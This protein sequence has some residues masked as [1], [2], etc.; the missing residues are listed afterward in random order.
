MTAEAG[1]FQWHPKEK[2]GGLLRRRCTCPRRLLAAKA[3]RDCREGAVESEI[4]CPPRVD[5]GVHRAKEEIGAIAEADF[6]IGLAHG[7]AGKAAEIGDGDGAG[8][9][10]AMQMSVKWD[11]LP[12]SSRYIAIE[13]V[14]TS[15]VFDL[16]LLSAEQDGSI[17]SPIDSD[18]ACLGIA[19]QCSRSVPRQ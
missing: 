13:I 19:K 9:G 2:G 12:T 15:R 18:L 14:R 1:T 5:A 8:P 4:T 7:D 3:D 6:G 16:R 11:G 17:D 10:G